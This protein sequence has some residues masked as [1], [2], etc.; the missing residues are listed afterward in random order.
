VGN[1]IIGKDANPVSSSN[2]DEIALRALIMQRS[3]SISNPGFLA[4]IPCLAQ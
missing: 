3:L 1:A 4:K 2:K